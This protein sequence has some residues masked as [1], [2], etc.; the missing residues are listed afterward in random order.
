MIRLLIEA[1]RFSSVS[2]RYRCMVIRRLHGHP[3]AE[4]QRLVSTLL[5]NAL[6]ADDQLSRKLSEREYVRP[7]VRSSSC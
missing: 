3:S 4:C 6:H 1:D 2:D 7:I 5:D